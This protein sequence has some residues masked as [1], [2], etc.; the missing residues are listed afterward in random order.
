M[1]T[2]PFCNAQIESSAETCVFCGGAQND[3]MNVAPTIESKPM[4]KKKRR[5]NA[6][7]AT[8]LSIFLTIIMLFA[9]SVGCAVTFVRAA[10]SDGVIE[11]V[12]EKTDI[13]SIPVGDGTVL[14]AVEDVLKSSGNEALENMDAEEIRALA[15]KAKLNELLSSVLGQAGGFITGETE[16]IE[17]S[18][19]QITALLEQNKENIYDATGYY[20]TE[21]DLETFEAE[22]NTYTEEINTITEQMFEDPAT[23][24]TVSTFRFVVGPTI[25]IAAF[26]VAGVCALLMLAMLRRRETTFLFISVAGFLLGG[27]L[28]G[29]YGGSEAVKNII[30]GN[31]PI[32]E[33]Y[34]AIADNIFSAVLNPVFNGAII[35]TVSAAVLLILYIVIACIM[36]KSKKYAH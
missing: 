8:V 6:W 16:K 15:E 22:I 32:P 34:A 10:F 21:E 5:R 7:W 26:S 30:F 18:A 35:A 27:A 17:I 28:F 29:I 33:G 1:K 2:C 11:A 4:P 23:K 24:A 3:I 19:E 13:L 31:F 14:D 20:I 9:L 25:P 12:V 36:K